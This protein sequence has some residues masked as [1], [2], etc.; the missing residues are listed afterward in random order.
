MLSILHID[1][2]CFYASCHQ[3]QK[4][5][6]RSKPVLVAGNPKKRHG[7]ILTA[8]YEARR[9]G[10]KTGMPIWQA[11]D[12]CPQGIFIKPNYS[13]YDDYN[14]RFMEI[15]KGYTPLVEPFSI[16]E[17]W[18]DVAGCYKI[19]G[20]AQ[21]IAENIQKTI[22]N[23]LQLPCS[24][25]VSTNKLLSKMASDMKK[26]LGITVI[27]P[28]QVPDTVWPL[29]V[30]DLIGVGPKVAL[31]LEALNIHTIGDLAKFSREL[32]RSHF[33]VMG[34]GLHAWA[35]GIDKSLVNP[36]ARD[37]KSIGHSITLPKDV[38]D[39][40]SA[41]GVLLGLAEQV[42][43][44]VRC[45]GYTGRVL[46]I[47]F[48]TSDFNTY[49]RSQTIKPTNLTE[50]IYSAATDLLFRHWDRRLPLRLIGISLSNLSRGYEQISL[51]DSEEKLKRLNSAVDTIRLRFGPNAVIR[52]RLMLR[53][54]P[55]SRIFTP[56]QT[57]APS[58]GLPGLSALKAP[59]RGPG[60][61]LA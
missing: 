21:T 30:K 13:L 24:I 39:M 46:A 26:P 60:R 19:F 7:I 40:E 55:T 6:L 23:K 11:Q 56:A 48:R 52:A 27:H 1:M 57:P 25:G 9:F 20:D 17:A 2:N 42:G 37:A 31:K 45:G 32:L 22:L 29:P 44:R 50:R 10:V 14:R 47:T 58:V 33:G 41:R 35:N 34:Q 16:D 36:H 38:H 28:E 61:P 4:P 8:S 43:F 54:S 53:E 12:L 3:A 59:L 18:L 5:K 49:T 15:L 51:F